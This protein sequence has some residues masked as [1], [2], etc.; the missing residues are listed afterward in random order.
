[1]KYQRFGDKIVVKLGVGDEIMSS[2]ASL[3]EQENVNAAEV[4]GIG[5]V[6]NV[7]LAF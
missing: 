3:A 6:D 7:K 5:A 1:M 4:A 2:I